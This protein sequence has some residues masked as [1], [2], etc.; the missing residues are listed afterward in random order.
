MEN[1]NIKD[2]LDIEQK[3]ANMIEDIKNQ[4]F[5]EINN[6]QIDGVN[7]LKK[8]P[9]IFTIKL[10]TIKENNMILSPEYY[11]PESQSKFIQSQL[12]SCK[13]ISSLYR[14]INEIITNKY[15]VIKS[16]KQ[17]LNPKTIQVL[18]KW[19]AD[20]NANTDEFFNT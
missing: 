11:S 5:T 8:N 12:S 10:S 14:K 16:T 17:P 3:I 20:N 2:I 18:E 15:V 6:N 19:I 9:T 13:T 4:I 1:L 7:V